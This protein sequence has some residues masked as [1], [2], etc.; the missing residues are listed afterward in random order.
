ML[1]VADVEANYAIVKAYQYTTLTSVQVKSVLW[2]HKGYSTYYDLNLH[3]KMYK[4]DNGKCC[5]SLHGPKVGVGGG[6]T[7]LFCR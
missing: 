4:V 1:G 6:K 3:R 5:I 7:E 2:H